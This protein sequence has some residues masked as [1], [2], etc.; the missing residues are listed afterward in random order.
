[1]V[2]LK[3]QESFSTSTGI[4]GDITLSRKING[5]TDFAFSV[6]SFFKFLETLCKWL[7]FTY[8][9]LDKDAFP[10]PWHFHEVLS[11][12]IKAVTFFSREGILENVVSREVGHEETQQS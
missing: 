3:I 6:S 8:L 2:S 11:T 5:E 1:M 10:S 12:K 4:F 7:F 9:N